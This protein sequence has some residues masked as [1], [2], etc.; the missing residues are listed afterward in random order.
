MDKRRRTK[1]CSVCGDAAVGFNFGAVACESC[2]AFFRRTATKSRVAPCLFNE[3]C[4]VDVATRRFCSHCRLRK[5]FSVGMKTSLILDE[6]AKHERREKI[7]RNRQK[8]STT[9]IAMAPL[10]QDEKSGTVFTQ[11]VP[12]SSAELVASSPESMD[13]ALDRVL[14]PEPQGVAVPPVATYPSDQWRTFLDASTVGRIYP[15]PCCSQ[16]ILLFL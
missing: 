14:S 10:D 9:E 13:E 8:R 2:K 4:K 6:K 16:L 7:K 11:N 3:Q 12:D 15:E 1:R 5:C